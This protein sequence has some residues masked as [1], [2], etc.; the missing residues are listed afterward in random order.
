MRQILTLTCPL[1]G[2]PL[3]VTETENGFDMLY[4]RRCNRSYTE[5]EAKEQRVAEIALF[6]N[7]GFEESA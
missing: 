1:D 3:D 4:C 2:T 6:E 7:R 5:T